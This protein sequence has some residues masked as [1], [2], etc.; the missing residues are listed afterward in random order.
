MR[1]EVELLEHHAHLLAHNVDVYLLAADFLRL[2]VRAGLHLVRLAL[3]GDVHALEEDRALGRLLEQVQRAQQG[4]LAAAGGADYDD[5][6]ALV[7]VYVHAVERLDGALVVV[8]LEAADADE[9]VGIRRMLG[10]VG[11]GILKCKLLISC[12][13][14][15]SSFQSGL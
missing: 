11:L 2:S 15:S 6:L 10:E 13:H 9:R 14:G 12:S 1:E 4:A 8:L 7:Y 3:L 5:D